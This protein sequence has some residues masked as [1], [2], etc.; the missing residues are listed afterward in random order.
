MTIAEALDQFFVTDESPWN[1]MMAI[2]LM[3]SVPP[4]AIYFALRYCMT[5][6][7]TVGGLKKNF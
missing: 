4:I 1:Y 3:Y 6:G 5:A 7:L 2:A